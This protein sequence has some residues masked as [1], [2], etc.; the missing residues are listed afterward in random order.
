MGDGQSTPTTIALRL[1]EFRSANGGA[2]LQRLR[3]PD[4]IHTFAVIKVGANYTGTILGDMGTALVRK[5]GHSLHGTG[6]QRA[7]SAWL[8]AIQ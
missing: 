1:V 3:L 2:C 7:S 4:H 6:D 8:F 5:Q